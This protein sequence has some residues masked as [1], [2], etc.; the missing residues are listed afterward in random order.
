MRFPPQ[1]LR[2]DAQRVVVTKLELKSRSLCRVLLGYFDAL[3]VLGDSN[4]TIVLERGDYVAGD[5]VRPLAQL[6]D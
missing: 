3:L 6:G 5:D 4:Q 2:D 1:I